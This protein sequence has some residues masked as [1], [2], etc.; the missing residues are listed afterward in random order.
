MSVGETLRHSMV[1][2]SSSLELGLNSVV[3]LKGSTV[4]VR[5]TVKV[6]SISNVGIG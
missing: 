1:D 2:S 6:R 4:E 5:V 3:V